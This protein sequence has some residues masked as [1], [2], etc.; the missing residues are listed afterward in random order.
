MIKPNRNLNNFFLKE[1]GIVVND[2]WIWWYR[3]IL[4]LLYV[5]LLSDFLVYVDDFLIVFV[6]LVV[7]VW[8][9]D[10]DFLIF[11]QSHIKIETSLNETKIFT[12]KDLILAV[13]YMTFMKLNKEIIYQL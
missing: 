2:M 7:D 6:M 11:R 5:E 10:K 12:I 8:P 9:P 3:Y 4:N 13:H 1:D